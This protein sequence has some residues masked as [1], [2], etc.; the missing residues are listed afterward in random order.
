ARPI[1]AIIPLRP[2]ESVE[3]MMS[4]DDDCSKYPLVAKPVQEKSSKSM[5]L[6][7]VTAL[8]R[9]VPIQKS[10]R[11]HCTPVRLDGCWAGFRRRRSATGAGGR[12]AWR[13]SH[14]RNGADRSHRRS[15]K[16][17]GVRVN[18]AGI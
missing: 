11:G 10:K 5:Y 13:A 12:M 14:A 7:A 16:G 9:A 15:V 17:P 2:V 3:T 8:V 1:L 6:Y 4:R 18:T